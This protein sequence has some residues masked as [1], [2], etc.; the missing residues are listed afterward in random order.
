MKTS[1]LS[2]FFI[3]FSVSI[4]SIGTGLAQP[5]NIELQHF[6][7]FTNMMRSGN[8]TGL[9][10]AS[11]IKQ[12][13]GT[14]GLG[15]LA[16]LTGEVVLVDGKLWISRGSQENGRVEPAIGDEQLVLWASGR[17]LKWLEVNIERNMKQVEFE[18]FVLR[19]AKEAKLNIEQPFLYRVTGQF[20]HLIW[21]V[22]TGKAGQGASANTEHQHVGH[23]N[24][25]GGVGHS[26][27]QSKVFRQ[28]STNGQL[29]G[30]YSGAALEGVVTHPGE[31]FHAHYFN[32]A[33]LVSGHLDQYSVVSGSK[34]WIGLPE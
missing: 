22:V 2:Y 9:V 16:G 7:H 21:H 29:I 20:E 10:N 13:P 23:A 11:Q 18:R 33:A 5:S 31:R 26:G 30:V 14:W 4:L 6:G 32:E 25:A 27:M 1:R 12:E 19:Q 34:L 24:H 3:A 17:A 15:A 8:T 28:P